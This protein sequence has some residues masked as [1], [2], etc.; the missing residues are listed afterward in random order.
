VKI[1]QR[2]ILWFLVFIGFSVNYMIRININI[3]LIDMLHKRPSPNRSAVSVECAAQE[4]ALN[5]T[6][7]S[8]FINGSRV[9]ELELGGGKQK[10]SLSLER[11]LLR[12]L[13]VMRDTQWCERVTQFSE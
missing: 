13:S 9:E 12:F 5:E 6:K 2:T 11:R 4:T 1:K 8:F 10:H 7:E 3:A